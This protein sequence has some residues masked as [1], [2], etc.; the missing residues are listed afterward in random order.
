MKK[1]IAVVLSLIFV[2][3]ATSLTLAAEKKKAP[4]P[5]KMEA[6]PAKVEAVKHVTGD[7]SAVDANAGTITVK[8]KKGNVVVSV[9]DMTQI[10]AGKDKKALADIKAGEKVTVVYTEADGKNTAKS[11]DIKPAHAK[12]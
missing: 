7:V 1:T 6:A 12:K 8:E 2:F 3:A 10:T 9:N 11:V 5:V 4:A